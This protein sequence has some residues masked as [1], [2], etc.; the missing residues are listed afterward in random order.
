MAAGPR[1][2][3]A[4]LG[5]RQLMILRPTCQCMQRRSRSIAQTYVGDILSKVTLRQHAETA[6]ESIRVWADEVGGD[7]S[8]HVRAEA[9]PITRAEAAELAGISRSLAAFH[10]EKLVAAE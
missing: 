8:S 2:S 6:V 3:G 10:L 1:L 9:N 7:L 5:Q 4:R